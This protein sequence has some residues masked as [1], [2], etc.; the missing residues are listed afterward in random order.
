MG[1]GSS[2]RSGYNLL[3]KTLE[4][5]IASGHGIEVFG[6]CDGFLA[7][8]VHLHACA[9]VLTMM[10]ECC[11]T[12]RQDLPSI[13]IP[14]LSSLLPRSGVHTWSLCLHLLSRLRTHRSRKQSWLDNSF[15]S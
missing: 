7:F 15:C 11:A 13:W 9:D 12:V 1:E 3:M 6:F 14:V 5:L 2:Y 8:L 4:E 10:C